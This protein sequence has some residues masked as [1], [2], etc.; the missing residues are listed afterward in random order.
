MCVLAC[1]RVAATPL[2]RWNSASRLSCAF[3]SI[4]RSCSAA[5]WIEQVSK[6][7]WACA[8]MALRLVVDNYAPP[9]SQLV[10]VSENA[11]RRRIKRRLSVA[12]VKRSW[13]YL[14]AVQLDPEVDAVA[15]NPDDITISKRA[16]DVALQKWRLS[17][18][19]L[20]STHGVEALL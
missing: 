7:P 19:A 10:D 3:H 14:F 12:M 13:E 8:N 15:P 18:R 4:I 6:Y 1:A 9:R 17:L 2:T 5:I 20:A 11:L 16:W